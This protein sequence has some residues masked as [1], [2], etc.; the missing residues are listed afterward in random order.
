MGCVFVVEFAQK[1]FELGLGRQR[2]G[3]FNV[4]E[5]LVKA[6]LKSGGRDYGH[7]ERA[8]IEGRRHIDRG[9]TG[10]STS[11]EQAKLPPVCCAK[12][13]SNSF[14]AR[15]T[16]SVAGHSTPLRN[17][18]L[19]SIPKATADESGNLFDRQRDLPREIE[20]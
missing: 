9:P 4:E 11:Q 6:E 1:G 17:I 13:D 15:V 5:L 20:L 16:A 2:V 18:P 8:K 12:Y 19:L 7:G 14:S 10:E 3:E